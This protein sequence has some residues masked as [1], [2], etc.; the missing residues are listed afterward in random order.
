MTFRVLT[1]TGFF[2]LNGRNFLRDVVERE[3]RRDRHR[4]VSGSADRRIPGE[5]ARS[6][7]PL[8]PIFL[9]IEYPTL[10]SR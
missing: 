7:L 10:A 8:L 6:L 2:L 4:S 9:F 1:T 3:R 5:R